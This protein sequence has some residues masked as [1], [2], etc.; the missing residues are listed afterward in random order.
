MPEKRFVVF[1]NFREVAI[2][3]INA[4]VFKT[5]RYRIH[6]L[7]IIAHR[8]K[9]KGLLISNFPSVFMKIFVAP[10][11]LRMIIDYRI[12]KNRNSI[13]RI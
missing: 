9:T 12:R 3:I 6:V 2:G 5:D 1:N 13:D 7:K 4:I 8:C 10:M 11:F